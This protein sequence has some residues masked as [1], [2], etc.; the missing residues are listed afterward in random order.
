[1]ENS[2][3]TYNLNGIA[4]IGSSKRIKMADY[5]PQGVPFYRSKEIIEKNKGNEI[6]TEL[7]I[8]EE[9]FDS[10]EAKFGAP[11]ELDILLTSVGTLGVPYQV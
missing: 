11:K 1:M 8:T 9:Q 4:D 10:I 5:V 6:S 3:N 7:F 2:W